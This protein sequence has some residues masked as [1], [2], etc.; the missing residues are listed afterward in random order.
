M[1]TYRINITQPTEKKCH[2]KRRKKTIQIT[3]I[4][5]YLQKITV[6]QL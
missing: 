4:N 6:S 2:I 3:K 5:S 1:K